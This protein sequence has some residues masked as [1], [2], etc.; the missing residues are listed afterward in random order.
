MRMEVDGY[1]LM[2]NKRARDINNANETLAC[3]CFVPG[4]VPGRPG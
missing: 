3:V 1:A 4:G 2:G